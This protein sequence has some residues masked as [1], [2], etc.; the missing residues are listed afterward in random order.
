MKT[1]F[2][3]AD[4]GKLLLR[5]SLAIN[6]L[7]HGA[8]KLGSGIAGI[9]KVVTDHGL[10]AIVAQGV[11]VGEILAPLLMLLGV[12]TR[13]A[14]AIFAFNMV[15]AVA[16]AHSNDVLTLGRH[17]A[18]KLELQGLYTFGA[19][20]VALLGAGRISCMRGRWH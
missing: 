16:L 15:V 18:W 1:R 13:P 6:M 5:A 7:M 19:I 12:F 10:P 14:A 3:L 8:H 4:W 17:G 9:T 20:A 11:Y 2:D